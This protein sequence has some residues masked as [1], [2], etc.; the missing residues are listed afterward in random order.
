MRYHQPFLLQLSISFNTKDEDS[1]PAAINDCIRRLLN[2]FSKT[3]YLGITATPFANIFIDPEKDDDLFPADFIYA[4]SAP[5]NYIGA[6]RIFGENSDSDHML[7]EIDIEELE[8]CFPPKHKKD[9]VVED[10]PEDLYEAAYYFLLLN[11]IRDYRGDLTEH[12]SMV[13]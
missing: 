11:A 13:L 5:T 12:R 4:L 6:D 1:Q 3:T 10:L 7:Q 8:A 2:L 9:F